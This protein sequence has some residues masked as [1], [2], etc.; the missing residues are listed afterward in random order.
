MPDRWILIFLAVAIIQTMLLIMACDS[1]I[2]ERRYKVTSVRI[3]SP[4]AEDWREL[5]PKEIDELN[6]KIKVT[7]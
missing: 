7:S 4:D 5:D 6:I 2:R 3:K 1:R